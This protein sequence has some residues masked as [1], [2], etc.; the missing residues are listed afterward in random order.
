MTYAAVPA[1]RAAARTLAAEWEPRSPRPRTTRACDRRREGGRPLRHGDDRAAGRLGR[2]RQH[3]ARRAGSGDGEYAAHR[4]QVVLLG[5]DVRRLPRPGAGA[6]RAVLLPPA[7]RAR[8]TARAT[9]SASS[10]SR[11][12]SATARTRR[13]EVELDGA[14]ARLRR[15]GGPRRRDDHRD[16]RP[17]AARLRARLDRAACARAVAEATHHAAHRS[18]F[19]RLLV[20]QPLMQNVLADLCLES[21]AATADRDAPRARLRRG[22]THAFRRLATA[23][24]K[25]WVCKRDAG[26]RRR[27]A[28]V[29]RRQRLRRGVGPAAPLPRERRSTRSGR[30]RATSTASTSCAR[31]GASRRALEAFLAELEPRPRSQPPPGRRDRPGSAASSMR[32][33]TSTRPPARRASG[34][35]PPGLAPRPPRARRGRG[36]ILRDPARGEGGRAYGT[37]PPGVDAA[38]IVE[39]HRPR[40]G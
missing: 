34:P 28:R 36:R 21:E 33:R 27:G 19:G 8:R 26:A 9:A 39:R 35:V 10:G 2:P 20:E 13:R 16:G 11:T 37:L 23:V 25:Y 32:P 6:G 1:L 14:W 38:A 29:P 12:S 4:A 15:R 7:A 17:H 22:T 5:A 40:V 24:A 30:G 3:D 18:A 31:S